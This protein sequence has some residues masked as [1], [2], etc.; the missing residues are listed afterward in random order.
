MID[1]SV[2]YVS[3][4]HKFDPKRVIFLTFCKISV[5]VAYDS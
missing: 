2:F 5:F 4:F 1:L 3:F